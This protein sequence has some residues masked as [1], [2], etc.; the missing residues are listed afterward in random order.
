MIHSGSRGL[1]HQVGGEYM[2][3]AASM[4]KKECPN[5]HLCY[6]PADS[7]EGRSYVGAMNAAANFAF[8]NRQFMTALVRRNIRHFLGDVE[9]P[10]VYDVPHNMAKKESHEG[11]TLWV[12]RKGATRVFDDARMINTPFEDSGQP[13]LIP[14]SMGTASYLMLPGEEAAKSLYSVNHG[15]GRVMS[16]TQAA[17]RTRKGRVVRPPAISDKDLKSSMEGIRLVCYNKRSVREEAPGAYKDIDLVAATVT[18]AKLGRVVAR[19]LP[20]AV[21]KG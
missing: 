7:R 11:E 3:T 6:M 17:G 2:K 14:G 9:L 8:A 20:R 10:L 5:A 18:G 16:R 21:L 15:A 1:G 4:T 19:M 13:A 12:H